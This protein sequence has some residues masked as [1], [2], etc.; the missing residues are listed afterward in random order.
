MAQMTLATN[1]FEAY[2]KT[3][4]KAEFLSR[5]DT[6]VPWSEFCAVIEPYYPKAGNGR[7]PIGLERMLRMIVADARDKPGLAS[8]Q[9]DRA[10]YR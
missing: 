6:L 3:T 5:M 2:R 1:G 4:R 8:L 10:Q 9:I 7:R